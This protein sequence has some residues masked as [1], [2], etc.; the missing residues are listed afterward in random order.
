M[1]STR[2]WMLRNDGVAYPVTQHIYVMNTDDLSSEADAASFLVYSDARDL[3]Y[4][5]YVLDCW[6]ALL[7]EQYVSY[8]AT[9]E[10]IDSAILS[11]LSNVPYHFTFELSDDEMLRI[12]HNQN[13]FNDVDSL[14]E[15]A[16]SVRSNLANISDTIKKSLNQQFC[17][18]RYGGQYRT[19]GS[20][21]LWFR[22]SSTGFNWADVMY[23]FASKIYYSYAVDYIYICRDYESDYG[24]EEG[25]PEYFYK[26]SDGTVYFHMPIEEYFSEEHESNPVFASTYVST[27]LSYLNDGH[28]W[29]EFSELYSNTNVNRH[30]NRLLKL[31]ESQCIDCSEFLD[32]APTRTRNKIAVMRRELERMYPEFKISDVDVQPYPNRKGN[33]V[34]LKYI[35]ELSSDNPKID[36]VNIDLAFTRGDTTPE[37]IKR[38]FRQEYEDFLTFHNIRI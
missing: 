12:H 35:F 9:S 1:A 17:R 29:L 32:N 6:M 8:D 5:E 33:M 4:A 23:E 37:T 25:H 19:E 10:E 14:Y 31:E 7:I 36:G 24:E 30:W 15:F 2:A 18:V 21:D 20:N 26:A 27:P 11:Q 34:G 13:N 38:R 3:Q 16:D 22:I 28:T